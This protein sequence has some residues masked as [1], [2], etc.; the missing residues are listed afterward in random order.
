MLLKKKTPSNWQLHLHRIYRNATVY[1]DVLLVFL[2]T[3]FFFILVLSV[4]AP[5]NG[6]SSS[7]PLVFY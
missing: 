6:H 1:V 2:I 3:E 7:H 4:D 5:S